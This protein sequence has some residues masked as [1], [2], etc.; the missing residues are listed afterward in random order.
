M[1]NEEDIN[2]KLFFE[3]NLSSI[4]N[5]KFTQREIDII[6]FIVNGRSTKKIASYL[7]ISPKTVENYVRNIML[8]L[9][10]NSR[11]TGKHY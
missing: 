1:Q 11:E 10:C 6:S 5:I 9:E 2:T 8:K 7:S 4:N 3:E